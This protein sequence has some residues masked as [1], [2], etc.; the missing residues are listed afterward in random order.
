MG[1]VPQT[2]TLTRPTAPLVT[3][4]WYPALVVIGALL[5]VAGVQGRIDRP[6]AAGAARI[7]RVSGFHALAWTFGS[8]RCTQAS[9]PG[10]G[11]AGTSQK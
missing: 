4:G 7:R 9:R 8:L 11:T 3:Y 1:D 2:T 10:G 5:A 6:A